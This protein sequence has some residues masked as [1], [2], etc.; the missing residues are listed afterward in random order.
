MGGNG[1]SVLKARASSYHLFTRS[2][3]VALLRSSSAYAIHGGRASVIARWGRDW[4]AVN[5]WQVCGR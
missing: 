1:T 2:K 5:D 4:D 3:G